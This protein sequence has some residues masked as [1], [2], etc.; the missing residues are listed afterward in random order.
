VPAQRQQHI[1]QRN[2]PRL[3]Q[4]QQKEPKHQ[5]DTGAEIARHR[6]KV[7]LDA[8]PG[9]M[10]KLRDFKQQCGCMSARNEAG[11]LT[12]ILSGAISLSM[13]PGSA[14]AAAGSSSAGIGVCC[15]ASAAH[16]QTQA[17]VVIW[18]RQ[19]VLVLCEFSSRSQQCKVQR[20][21]L[22]HTHMTAEQ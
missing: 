10:T 7:H 22:R 2:D 1:S 14:A 17:K 5:H 12:V 3:Y 11:L 13:P 16:R 18:G 8:P 19:H 15:S 9:T 21:I 4:E 20:C 6:H